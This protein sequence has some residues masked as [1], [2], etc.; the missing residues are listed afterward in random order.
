MDIAFG[1]QWHWFIETVCYGNM[2]GCIWLHQGI[3][4]LAWGKSAEYNAPSITDK[5]YKHKIWLK[6]KV[7]LIV[8]YDFNI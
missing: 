2:I 1:L 6:L 4:V 8:L 5:M 3:W 7:F